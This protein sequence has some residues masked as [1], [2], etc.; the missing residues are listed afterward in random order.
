LRAF[1][2]AR[3]QKMSNPLSCHSILS[4]F[5]VFSG[6]FVASA[7]AQTTTPQIAD[8]TP[9]LVRICDD[10]G[11]TERPIHTATF[12][13]PAQAPSASPPRVQRLISLA[14]ANPK[15]AYDLGLRYFRGD[16]VERD[17]YQALQW[18]RTAGDRGV[19]D[20]QLALGK[21]YL[22]GLEEMGSDPAEAESWL[23]KAASNGSVEAAKL[24]PQA[25]RAKNGAQVDYAQREKQRTTWYILW[26]RTAPY[27]WYWR[28]DSWV[29]QHCH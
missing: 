7:Q 12:D 8:A 15:A 24:L 5:L 26:H 22:S 10:S 29:C 17:S 21:L 16:G 3:K 2:F 25:T 28:G 23:S 9:S 4:L 18:M 6:F 14:E 1:D 27:Y 20:A 11:C 13:T 19:R